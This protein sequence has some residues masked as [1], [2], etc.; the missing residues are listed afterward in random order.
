MNDI[1]LNLTAMFNAYSKTLTQ[2]FEAT[3]A[4]IELPLGRGRPRE[5]ALR[6]FLRDRLPKRYGVGEGYVI[7]WQATQSKQ[8]D[9]VIYDANV[10][11]KF[12]VDNDEEH[13]LYPIEGVYAGI[14]VKSTL[15]RDTLNDSLANARQF[16]KVVSCDEAI[17]RPWF[18]PPRIRP[19]PSVIRGV[20]IPC[21]ELEVTMG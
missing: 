19:S 9:I 7:N 1:R 17:P 21:R 5:N 12:A 14:E 2:A 11:P 10:C 18:V 6:I 3:Q 16:K 20:R 4:A 15:N 8:L 13:T